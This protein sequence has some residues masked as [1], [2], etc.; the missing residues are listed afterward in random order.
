VPVV[1]VVPPGGE[2][3]ALAAGATAAVPRPVD[4]AA[5]AAHV[6]TAVRAAASARA[7]V[8]GRAPDPLT[9]LDT[10]EALDTRLAGLVADARTADAALPCVLV[11]VRDLGGFNRTHGWATGDQLLL[12]LAAEI[13]DRATQGDVPCRLGGATFA[14]LLP[15]RALAYANALRDELE[16]FLARAK[17]RLGVA[18]VAVKMRLAVLDAAA[19]DNVGAE[20]L[21]GMLGTEE[22]GA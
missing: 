22:R 16:D 12:W 18:R 2:P 20:G 17:P 8:T 3:A 14:L 1:A 10:A 9:G 7:S 11:T 19:V 6:R 13:R 15:G 21:I 4:A 5:L